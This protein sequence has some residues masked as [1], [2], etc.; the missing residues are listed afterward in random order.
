[1]NLALLTDLYQLTMAQGYWKLARQDE[2]ACF[3]LFFRKL[4]FGG[5][6][7]IACGIQP[8]LD[9]LENFHFDRNE[10]EYLAT[11]TGNDDKPL[12]TTDFLDYLA[13]LKFTARVMAVREG[14]VVFPLQPII[15]INGSIIQAQLVESFLLNSI[16]FET[17]IATKA[18]RIVSAARGDAVLEFGLRRAQ[19]NDGALTASRAAFVGG[20]SATSNVLAGYRY[21]IPV[22]GTHAHSWVMSFD[23]EIESFRSY[24]RVMPNNCVF[25]V[26]TYD[27]LEGVK[28]AILIGKELR[29]M[30]KQFMGIRLDSGDL[31]FLS[32][33]A[34]K[35][36]TEAGFAD[37]KIYA[38]NDLDEY[39]IRDIKYQNAKISVWGV[40]TKL[41]TSYDQPALGGVYK[42]TARQDKDGNWQKTIKISE[43]KIKINIPGVLQI[44]RYVHNDLFCGDMIYDS[45]NG[46]PQDTII[47]DPQNSTRRKKIQAESHN[48]LLIPALKDGQRL[49]PQED[50]FT[51]QKRATEQLNGFH[52]GIKRFQNPHEYPIGL[53]QNLHREREQMILEARGF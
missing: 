26:D 45:L 20:C 8:A 21:G 38:S 33:Q 49:Y 53:E 39:L 29:S 17:L 2:Q 36:L 9:Y 16:N 44:R 30:G 4:P 3:N 24:A 35:L 50:I 43:Q 25:L 5:G 22:K 11:L 42:L 48:D 15:Q 14:T 7:A 52:I 51:V 31:T 19:G 40:G 10:L 23:S 34:Q 32:Q 27:T 28:N 1:M 12:F 6:Y 41:I 18:S 13:D 47:I 37:A 46:E